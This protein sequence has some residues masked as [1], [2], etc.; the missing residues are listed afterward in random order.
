MSTYYELAWLIPALPL[1]SFIIT[2]LFTRNYKTLT[3]WIA[4][5]AVIASFYLSVRVM[6]DMYNGAGT[7]QTL[8]IEWIPLGKALEVTIGVYLDP[9]SVMMLIVV[10]TVSMLVHIYSL[11]YMAHEDGKARFFSFLS[12]FT[13]SMLGLVL[14]DNVLQMFIFWELVGLCSYLLIGYYYDKKSAADAAK[15]AFSVTRAGDLGFFMAVVIA[16]GYFG[17]FNFAEI[18]QQYGQTAEWLARAFPFLIFFGAMGKSGQFPL[19]IWLPDAMEGPTPVSALI[20]A[21]TMV[22]A[23]IFLVARAVMIFAGSPDTM[24]FVA[25]IGGFTAIFAATIAVAQH[26]IKRILAFSTLSQ[27]GYMMMALG[28]GG[29][30]GVDNFSH[31]HSGT[32]LALMGQTAGTFHLFTHAFFKALLF[33]GSGSVIHAMHTNNIW[34]MGGVKSKMKITVWTFLIGTL[35]LAGIPPF[36]GFWSKDEILA[37][38]MEVGSIH[39]YVLFGV[40]L[41][42]AFFTAFYMFRLCFV[43]F[44][45]EVPE[46]KHPHESPVS[47]T[48]PLVLLGILSVIAGLIGNADM[49]N[50]LGIKTYAAF[51]NPSWEHEGVFHISIAAISAGVAL[52]GILVAYVMYA[53]R[54]PEWTTEMHDPLRSKLGQ[55]Y[56]HLENKWYIDEVWRWIVNQILFRV[57]AACAWFDRNIVD[58]SVDLVAF[59]TTRIGILMQPAQS[60]RLQSYILIVMLGLFIILATLYVAI[61]E[62]LV[63]MYR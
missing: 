61:P 52:L 8:T 27:L 55:L 24:L 44:W 28:I 12:L 63:A 31:G 49:A 15:K 5:A 45:G 4:C 38:A 37:L 26:D 57:S 3:A 10:T 62:I 58:G 29:M 46:K 59:I 17:T 43:A 14:S 40:G 1:F 60:G 54:S 2:V 25:Y 34:E 41:T 23:G 19:H 21:A 13:F 47:M 16:W 50:A 56:V 35:A 11:G 36:A 30:V 53:K 51:L 33:L 9:L 42:A 7:A 32:D 22:V 48:L 18:Q 39:G 20:H 6:L